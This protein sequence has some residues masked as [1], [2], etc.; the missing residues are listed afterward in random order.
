MEMHGGAD[1]PP[2]HEGCKQPPLPSPRPGTG[3]D[4]RLWSRADRRLEGA[5]EG[6]RRG[7]AAR[8]PPSSRPVPEGADPPRQPGRYL[9]R[10]PLTVTRM[11]CRALIGSGAQEVKRVGLRL[12]IRR[13]QA[14]AGDVVVVYRDETEALTHPYLAHAWAPQGADLRVAAPGQAR[15]VAIMGVFYA[16]ARELIVRT[17]TTKRSTDFIALPTSL[18]GRHGPQPGRAA[19][20][21]G[22]C[23]TTAPSPPAGPPWPPSRRGPGSPSSGC[24][25]TRPS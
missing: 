23:S 10:V 6:L 12:R 5:E 9:S 19:K 17:S 18:D 24:R 15:K 8:T 21:A 20:P 1:G 3:I 4:R 14:E 22:W 2:A 7:S 16:A 13:A 11:I 25:A